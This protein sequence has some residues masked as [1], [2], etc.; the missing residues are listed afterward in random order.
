MH[1]NGC[2]GREPFPTLIPIPTVYALSVDGHR[3]MAVADEMHPFP[4]DKSCVYQRNDQY[5]DPGC[6]GCKHKEEK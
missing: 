4:F 6:T 2:W 3:V 1:K 5:N